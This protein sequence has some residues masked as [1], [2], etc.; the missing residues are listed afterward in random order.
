M[1]RRLLPLT[2]V[3][4]LQ[5]LL[6]FANLDLLPIWTDELF[7]L[8]TVRKPVA[9]IIPIL[10]RDVHPPLYY[11]LLHGW[12]GHSLAGLRAFSALWA[13]IATILLDRLWTKNWK[14]TRRWLALSL[15]GLSPCLLLYGRMARSYS[16]QT[17]LTLAA[18]YLLWRWIK[19][20]RGAAPAFLATALVLYTHYVPGLAVLGAFAI[21][22]WSR[23]GPR[24]VVPFVAGVGAGYLPWLLTLSSALGRWGQAAGFS[25]RFAVTGSA[26]LEQPV[27][28]GF[29]VVSLTIGESFSGVSLLL[30]PL[31]LWLAVQGF[32]RGARV[33]RSLAGMC[34]AAAVIGYLG[35]SRWVSYPFIPARLLWLLPFLTLSVAMGLTPAGRTRRT[36]AAL[37]L[38]C[39]AA[40]TFFYFRK[41]NF[42]NKGYAAPLREIASRLNREAAPADVI[43]IDAHNTDGFALLRYLSGRTPAVI[44]FPELEQDAARRVSAARAVWVV[45]NQRDVSPGAVTSRLESDACT[46][47]HRQVSRYEPYSPWQATVLKL[48]LPQ[49]PTHFYQLTACTP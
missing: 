22:A 33:S 31:V 32:R 12:P 49:P 44:L 20:Q 7:T 8:E 1:V 30:V 10:R 16:M 29:G 24:R 36:A 15:F 13:L 39:S 45:R 28:I 42:L 35:V 17:A 3:V 25:S 6:H 38:L 40:S 5:A 4:G 34:A 26:W 48:I 14:P 23:L 21:A 2:V 18:V 9:E 11:F 43:L 37:L 47:R 19:T 27:K 46:P 41:E